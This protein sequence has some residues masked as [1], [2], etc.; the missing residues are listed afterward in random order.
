ML[1]AIAPQA[2][3]P[4]RA[5]N[6]TDSLRHR[7]AVRAP[8]GAP[9]IG[10]FSMVHLQFHADGGPRVDPV[11]LA[12]PVGGPSIPSSASSASSA[13]STHPPL[14]PIIHHP[15]S[16]AHHRSSIINAV[17]KRSRHMSVQVQAEEGAAAATTFVPVMRPE[18]L[19]KG[20]RKEVRVEGKSVL[21]FWYRNQIYAIESRSPAEGA[22]SEG[23]IRAKFTQDFGIECPSTGT[24]FSLKDGSIQSWYPNNPVLRMLTP[25]DTCRK[26]EIYPVKLEQDAISVDVSGS[27][28]A[29]TTQMTKGGSDTSLENN[30]VYGLEPRMYVEGADTEESTVGKVASVGVS[31]LSV[32]ALI[33]VGVAVVTYISR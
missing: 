8:V 11:G 25:Q 22:Y 14:V 27:V 30:N 12:T 1:L 2:V 21:L 9:R 15:S 5:T 17:R 18:D 20:V 19:P 33:A 16:I 29:N 28:K 3:L 26:L 31:V 10:A 6:S 13:S 7:G 23:F 24:L 32:A 4:R